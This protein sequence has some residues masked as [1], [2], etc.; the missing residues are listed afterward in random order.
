MGFNSSL[1]QLVWDLKALLLL[2]LLFKI[3]VTQTLTCNFS[4][5]LSTSFYKAHFQDSNLVIFNQQLVLQKKNFATKMYLK[6]LSYSTDLAATT[7]WYRRN[8]MSKSNLGD[9]AK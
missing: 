1:P 3:L 8:C 5:A 7:L 6:V 2:L 4:T 9:H